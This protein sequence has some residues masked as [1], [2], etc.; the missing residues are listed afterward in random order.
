MNEDDLKEVEARRATAVGEKFKENVSQLTR[1]EL[2]IYIEVLKT[3]IF[4][5]S[6]GGQLTKHARIETPITEKL[7]RLGLITKSSHGGRCY[8]PRDDKFTRPELVEMLFELLVQRTSSA[9]QSE[10]LEMLSAAGMI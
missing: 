2:S 8:S 5:R 1:D 4:N 9:P 10:Y 7:E 3:H 6:F